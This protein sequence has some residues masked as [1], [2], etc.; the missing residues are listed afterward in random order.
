MSELDRSIATGLQ[1]VEVLGES[2]MVAAALEGL[3]KVKAWRRE[4]EDK[5]RELKVLGDSAGPSGH[6]KLQVCDVCG[7]Y[8][9]RLDNDRRLAD[10]FYGKVCIPPNLPHF[11]VWVTDATGAPR[12][13]ASRLRIH[14]QRTQAA[15][16]RTREKGWPTALP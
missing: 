12:A 3:W 7:A 5:G 14:A 15:P 16:R 1:E 6:Q 13:D 4:K 10:H 11:L 2:G 8:L 9:S